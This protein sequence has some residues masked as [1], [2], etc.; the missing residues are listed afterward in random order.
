[1]EV[2]E[3]LR[4]V[5]K[6]LRH[7]CDQCFGRRLTHEPDFFLDIL[8]ELMSTDEADEGAGHHSKH[9]LL[10]LSMGKHCGLNKPPL[11]PSGD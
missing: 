3:E 5:Y 7:L 4:K 11:E 2:M 10:L 6:I 1:M 9:W 8:V